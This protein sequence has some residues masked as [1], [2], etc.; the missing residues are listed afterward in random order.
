MWC[1]LQNWKVIECL[2]C[3]CLLYSSLMISLYLEL[4]GLLL[5]DNASVHKARIIKA[6][7]AKIRVDE[8]KHIGLHRA[9]TITKVDTVGVN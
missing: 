4:G 8:L 1:I 3:L 9:L 7:V 5:H 6:W 2:E